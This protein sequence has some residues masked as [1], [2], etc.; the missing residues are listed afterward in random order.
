MYSRNPPTEDPEN[1]QH[2]HLTHAFLSH[3]PNTRL[4][5]TQKALGP[6]RH[7]E[8]IVVGSRC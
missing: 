8:T 7:P 6:L 1:A 4:G 5:L 2:P 3:P